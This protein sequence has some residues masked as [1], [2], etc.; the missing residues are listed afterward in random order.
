M[1]VPI[2]AG[3]SPIGC[4]KRIDPIER[5]FPELLARIGSG[6]LVCRN[7]D[8][9]FDRSQLDGLDEHA[10]QLSDGGLYGCLNRHFQQ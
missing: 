6:R 1:T 4:S 5:A 7:I 8:A 2:P 3:R 9:S 10:D